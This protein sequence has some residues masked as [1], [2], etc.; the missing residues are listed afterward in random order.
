VKPADL[1]AS[2]AAILSSSIA[3]LCCLLPLTILVL[4]LGSGA[5]LAG[6]TRYSSVFIPAGALGLGLAWSLYV[7]E[8]RRCARQGCAMGG[9][10]LNLA[11]LLASTVVLV[12]A[13]TLTALPDSA[14]PLVAS[15]DRQAAVAEGTGAL[16][17]GDAR[18][19]QARETTSSDAS[20]VSLPRVTLRVEGMY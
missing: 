1:K 18:P 12:A 3:S 17:R 19:P 11:V 8:R 13:V 16:G 14:A 2:L 7:R 6:T 9:R 20:M 10:R 15:W 5:F 4:G